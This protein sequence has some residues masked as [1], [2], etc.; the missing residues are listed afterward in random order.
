MNLFERFCLS[1]KLN[2][3]NLRIEIICLSCLTKLCLVNSRLNEL[4]QMV[5]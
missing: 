2:V 4:F 3:K 5:S 1:L